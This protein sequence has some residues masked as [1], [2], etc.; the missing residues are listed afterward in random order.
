MRQPQL[1]TAYSGNR[2]APS[3]SD[4]DVSRKAAMST[5]IILRPT[6]LHSG[7]MPCGSLNEKTL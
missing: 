5:P 4:L 1:S 3:L 7:H 2:I 6:P